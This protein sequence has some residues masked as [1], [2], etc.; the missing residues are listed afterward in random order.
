MTFQEKLYQLRRERSLSQEGL[1][2]ALGVSRQAVQKWESGAASPDT[3]NLIALSDF[4]GVT[5]DSLLKNDT[6]ALAPALG[7]GALEERVW[8]PYH[9]E[10]KS[11][12]TLFGLP[13]V[14]IHFGGRR[15][16]RA[17]GIIAIGD[18][19]T[20]LFAI[21][22]IAAGLIS[23]GGL[24]AGLLALGGLAIGMFAA[25]RHGARLAC[26]RGGPCGRRLF[27]D[28]R[29][30]GQQMLCAWRFSG[31]GAHRGG[32]DSLCPGC[33]WGGGARHGFTF[34]ERTFSAG[35]ARRYFGG[36]ASY[37]GV[38]CDAFCI[39]GPVRKAIFAVMRID[40]IFT[41]FLV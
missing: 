15:V 35:G 14:H 20:G 40:L 10:Y 18:I 41:I 28:G 32:R 17:K 36:A 23:L 25:R 24:S 29:P 9:Y 39:G 34:D 27:C 30:G 2:S 26:C 4:F 8:R 7:D 3:N 12:R 31:C 11:R 19:A 37:A 13:L 38:D 21:G 22:G 5:L 33:H 16:C 6:A 1:A